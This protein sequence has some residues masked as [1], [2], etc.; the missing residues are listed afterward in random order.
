M[1]PNNKSQVETYPFASYVPAIVGLV[2]AIVLAV[3]AFTAG[4]YYTTSFQRA[5]QES[6]AGIEI[7]DEPIVDSISYDEILVPAIIDPEVRTPL[8][9]SDQ[10]STAASSYPEPLAPIAF[11]ASNTGSGA[12]VILTWQ[13]PAGQMPEESDVYTEVLRATSAT[14]LESNPTVLASDVLDTYYVDSTVELGQTYYYALRS[15]RVASGKVYVSSQTKS[16]TLLVD[17]VLSPPAPENVRVAPVEESDSVIK[18]E[19]DLDRT[20]NS[21]G[22]Y[23]YRSTRYGELGEKV[24]EV[25]GDTAEYLDDVQPSTVYYYTVTA[26]DASGNESTKSLSAGRPGNSQPMYINPTSN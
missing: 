11:E 16:V 21:D 15:A 14:A 9:F 2:V 17:D 23:I 1:S 4:S 19:W 10:V 6:S 8:H 20:D 7:T 3:V 13:Q 25:N 12:Q 24:G 5:T 18:V 22:Y 26:V